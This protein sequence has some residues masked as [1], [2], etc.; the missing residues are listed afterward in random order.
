V[1][2]YARY[3]WELVARGMYMP[4]SQFEALFVSAAHT[5]ADIAATISA[6][7]DALSRV[8]ATASA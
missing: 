2:L 4:C 8:A 7:T 3:F 6:T 5:D 1:Q